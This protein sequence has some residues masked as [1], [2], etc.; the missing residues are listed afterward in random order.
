MKKAILSIG[1]IV[2]VFLLVSLGT[3][4]PKVHSQPIMDFIHEVEAKENNLNEQT[5]L[6]VLPNPE[7]NGIIWTEPLLVCR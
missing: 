3:A 1:A 6:E 7:P 5:T 4:V 2:T